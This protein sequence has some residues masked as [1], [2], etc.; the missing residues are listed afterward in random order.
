MSYQS[1]VDGGAHVA[2]LSRTVKL[3][4]IMRSTMLVAAGAL[5]TAITGCSSGIKVSTSAAPEANLTALR[6]FYVLAPPAR[7]ADAAALSVNDPMLDNSI[8]NRALRT[9]LTQAFAGRGYTPASRQAADFL[10]AYYA[11]TKE[12]F[13]TTY[14][15]PTWDPAWRYTYWGRRYSAWPWYAGTDPW[16]GVSVNAYTQGRVIVDVIEPK[17]QQLIWRGQGVAN[18]SDDPTTYTNELRRSVNAIL[19]KFPQASPQ[20]VALESR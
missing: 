3:G 11:G 8:T 13:D 19:A 18:A 17:T 9:D 2:F 15:G 6:T 1:V 14:Y 5:A 4:G 20:S 7:R 10:V 16:G 12:K